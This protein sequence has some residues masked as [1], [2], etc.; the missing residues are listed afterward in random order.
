[1]SR[2]AAAFLFVPFFK[3]FIVIHFNFNPEHLCKIQSFAKL[4]YH[5]FKRLIVFNM[6]ILIFIH[7]TWYNLPSINCFPSYKRVVS[8][9][10]TCHENIFSLI[11]L[12]CTSYYFLAEKFVI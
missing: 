2:T 6:Y 10:L 5:S 9:S 12:T 7:V 1:M 11:F 8:L 4:A 3:K